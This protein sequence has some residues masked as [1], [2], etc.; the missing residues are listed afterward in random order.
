MRFAQ[1]NLMDSF[2]AKRD[3]EEDIFENKLK[4]KMEENDCTYEEAV[5]IYVEDHDKK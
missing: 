2:Y 1:S 4:D 3:R 5:D